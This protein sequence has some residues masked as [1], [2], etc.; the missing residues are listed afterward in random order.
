[1]AA[2][3]YEISLFMLKKYFIRSLISV[4]PCNILDLFRTPRLKHSLV[5]TT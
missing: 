4:Q 1:M 2:W 5:M 3:R